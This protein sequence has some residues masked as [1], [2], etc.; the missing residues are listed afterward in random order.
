MKSRVNLQLAEKIYFYQ[1]ENFNTIE[2]WINA[3]CNA[4]NDRLIILNQQI[5]E[6]LTEHLNR[7]IDNCLASCQYHFF[8]YDGPNYKKLIFT[9]NTICWKLF[10]IIQMENLNIQM[11]SIN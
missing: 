10:F 7:A 2:Q 9:F 8:S 3:A 6:K 11:K 1:R 4:L 5:S